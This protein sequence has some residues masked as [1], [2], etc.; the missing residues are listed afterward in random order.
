MSATV[1]P[2][3]HSKS[4]RFNSQFMLLQRAVGLHRGEFRICAVVMLPDCWLAQSLNFGLETMVCTRAKSSSVYGYALYF[5]GVRAEIS[6][7][8]PWM[9]RCGAPRVAAPSRRIIFKGVSFG[10][11][12]LETLPYCHKT[13][14]L[15]LYY[16][17]SLCTYS[18]IV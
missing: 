2:N 7:V 5:S 3:P 10:M 17:A 15:Y 12:G 1:N 6:I 4:S 18:T 14:S 9:W 11:P 8:K 13:V 16:Y